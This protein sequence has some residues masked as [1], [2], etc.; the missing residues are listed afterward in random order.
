MG[1]SE[2]CV[3]DQRVLSRGR[4]TWEDAAAVK[5]FPS[6][7]GKSRG[8]RAISFSLMAEKIESLLDDKTEAA[9]AL[10]AFEL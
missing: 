8:V 1:L 7:T 4:C 10:W 3:T 9:A 6:G 5:L 2:N